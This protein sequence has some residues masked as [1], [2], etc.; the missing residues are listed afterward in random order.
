[1]EEFVKSGLLGPP[2]LQGALRKAGAGR[3]E[4][5]HHIQRRPRAPLSARQVTRCPDGGKGRRSPPCNLPE[6]W[7]PCSNPRPP[8]AQIPHSA[9]SRGGSPPCHPGSGPPTGPSASRRAHLAGGA[10][11]VEG[12]Q[13]GASHMGRGDKRGE[14]QWGGKFRSLSRNGDH[15]RADGLTRIP[16]PL[17]A[18][19]WGLV[20][21]S[22]KAVAVAAPQ[23]TYIPPQNKP[24]P[25]P[26]MRTLLSSEKHQRGNSS[27]RVTI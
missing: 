27:T 9:A 6:K 3:V 8:P 23:A 11:A 2:H 22:D 16:T 25:L 7:V 20:A 15:R 21:C 1:M 24:V 4:T 13:R 26:K 19:L 17:C 5:N 18:R 14:R 10:T 12:G